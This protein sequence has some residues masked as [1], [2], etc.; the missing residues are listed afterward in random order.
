MKNQIHNLG[1]RPEHIVGECFDGAANMSSV[2][3]ELATRMKEMCPRVIYDPCYG[4]L[5]N[6]ALQDLMTSAE[7]DRN[8]ASHI[9]STLKSSSPAP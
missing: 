1:L 5:L 3:I 6:L 7:P 9:N 4:Y 8:E 2:H